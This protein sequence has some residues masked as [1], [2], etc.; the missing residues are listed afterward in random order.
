MRRLVIVLVVA[1]VFLLPFFVIRAD[2]LDDITQQLA[3]LN[4]DLK[5]K[6]ADYQ[7]LSDQLDGIKSRVAFLEQEIVKKEREVK[8]GEQTLEYQK[9]LL[10]ERAKSYYKNISKNADSFL[11]LLVASDLSTSLQNFFY[12]KTVVDQDRDTIIK[13]VLYIKNLEDKKASLAREKTSLAAVQEEIDRQSKILA[14]EI[15]TTQSK[16]VELTARQQEI[17]ASRLAALN[18]PRSAATSLSGCVDDREKDPGFSPR[19]ALFTYGVPNRIGLNQYG[20]KGRA[21]AG[22]GYEDIL[23]A[24]YNFDGLQDASTDIKIR[25]DGHGEYPL[26]DYV[27]RIYEMPA[28]WSME[29]LK[30]QAVAARSYALAYTNNGAGSICDSTSCQVFKDEEKGGRWNEAVDATRGKVMAQGG[31]PIKAWFSSTHGGYVLS[32]GEVPGWSGTS[33]TKHATDTTSGSAGSFGDLQSNAYDRSSPWFYCDWGARSNYSNTAWLTS[34]EIADIANTL[35]LV[36]RDPATT[37]H[38]YQTDKS[39]PAGTDTWDEGKVRQE[40]Q[41]R[42]GSPFT[43][44]SSISIGADFGGGRTITVTI[45]GN[46]SESFNGDEWKNRFNLRAPATIQIVGPLYNAEIR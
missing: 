28:D 6:Q 34:A 8:L 20:A 22:Q 1:A 29:A 7:K 38:L 17:L 15:S 14:G 16:I 18:I 27:K 33:W 25:V 12:Q 5:S 39:N 21:E 23:R 26:E 32:S 37:E 2:E 36:K 9:K 10:N 46:K 3:A 30:A 31:S 4:E 45:S 41:N 35:L 42:G 19:F 24:Y 11:M 43:S 40:L 13:I 44:V